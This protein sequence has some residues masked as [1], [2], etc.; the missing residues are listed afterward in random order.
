LSLKDLEPLLPGFACLT[1]KPVC[2]GRGWGRDAPED[3]TDGAPCNLQSWPLVPGSCR[4]ETSLVAFLQ[5]PSLKLR[6]GLLLLGD[7]SG[8]ISAHC[9]ASLTVW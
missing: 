9:Y 7:H 2:S 1:P 6:V 4:S 8:P 3:M 5:V